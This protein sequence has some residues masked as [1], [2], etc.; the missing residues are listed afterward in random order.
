[1]RIL[2]IHIE[3]EDVQRSFNMYSQLIPHSK[4]IWWDERDAVAMVLED[5]SAFGLWKKGKKGIHSGR[6]GQ[7]VH[8]A[9]QIAPSEY[10]EYK[11]KIES[12][13]LTP[14][15]HTWP[16]GAKSV[17]FFDS[18]GHQGEFMTTDWSSEL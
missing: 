12:L 5:G 14:L 15:E 16:R 1:M 9:F 13:G 7:H 18:D 10:D 3:V 2:E 8:F 4:V 6:A 17:Y 11:R